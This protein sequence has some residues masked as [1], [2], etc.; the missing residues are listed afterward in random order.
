MASLIAILS[1][2]SALLAPSYA[3]TC[4]VCSSTLAS[5]CSGS[6]NTCPS[7]S[8]C[9][10]SYSEARAGGVTTQALV[11]ECTPTSQ[12]NFIGSIGIPQGQTRMVTACCNTD[13][14][15]PTIPT[16]P[17][18][19]S[20]P[21]GQVCRSCISLDSNWC[22]TSDTLQCTGNENMCLLQTT[23]VTGSVS[24][25]TAIRGCATKSVCDI[26]SQSQSASGISSE[27]KFICTSAGM[28]LHK[29]VLTPA[30]ACLLLLKFF[31]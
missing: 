5:T 2:L 1:L 6:S 31:F 13:N 22:Y 3:L 29:V 19:S 14:C 15:T 8:V 24:L 27:V 25:S 12:C 7:G 17:S 30:I 26:G 20:V 11:R 21:N 9:G 28:S 23:K 16:L 10:S 4:T 18:P